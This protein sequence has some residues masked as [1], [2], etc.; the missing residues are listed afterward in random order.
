[1]DVIDGSEYYYKYFPRE[2]LPTDIHMRFKA[3]FSERERWSLEDILPYI[4][5]LIGKSLDFKTVQ[6]M[7][8]VHARIAPTGD[9]DD[10]STWYIAR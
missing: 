5:D 8:T 3:L 4:N 9:G 10:D 7:L 6:D 2:L 1:M